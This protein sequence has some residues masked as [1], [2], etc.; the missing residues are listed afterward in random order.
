MPANYEKK[1]IEGVSCIVWYTKASSK[2]PMKEKNAIKKEKTE[3]GERNRN[4]PILDM[5]GVCDYCDM[6]IH[7]E[8]MIKWKQII[9]SEIDGEKEIVDSG[10][11]TKVL[12]VPGSIPY[13]SRFHTVRIHAKMEVPCALPCP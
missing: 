8:N 7:S 12:K 3:L 4:N 6:I 11:A 1:I 13:Q 9:L 10:D 2:I 5:C